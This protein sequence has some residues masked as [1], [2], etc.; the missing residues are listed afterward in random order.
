[1][2]TGFV[3]VSVGICAYNEVGRV[4]GLLESLLGQAVPEPFAL[5]EIVVVASGCTDGT[6]RV[7]RSFAERDCRVQL[8]AEPER[9]G[10]ASALNQILSVYRGEVLV[11][12]NADARLGPDALAHLLPVFLD[13]AGT[14]VACGAAALESPR[15]LPSLIDGVLWD[16][17]NR[18]LAVQSAR[19]LDNHCCD[20][21]MAIRRGFVDSLPPD[22]IN[23]GAYLGVLAALSGQTVRFCEGARVFVRP[24]RTLR[25][26]LERRKRILRGH[27][28]VRLL[29]HRSSNTLESLARKDPLLAARILA[30]EVRDHPW[31]LPIL[32]LLAIPL[33]GL[34]FALAYADGVRSPAYSAV[35]PKVDSL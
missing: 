9:L 20:E 4:R 6:E 33:E 13:P 35:W 34:S 21:L 25:G 31:A 2:A 23:D 3:T 8:L 5:E 26:W 10:K 19:N 11:L 27:R 18:I 7:V 22:L 12:A 30:E 29:L 17:H 24:P 15:G 1:M 32:L 28:Q 16:L 14:R